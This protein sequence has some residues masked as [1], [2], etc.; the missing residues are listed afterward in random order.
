MASWKTP[1]KNLV[2]RRH[3]SQKAQPA[4][5]KMHRLRSQFCMAQEVG[6]VLGGRKI[7]QRSLP[8][9][10]FQET[11]RHSQFR[12]KRAKPVRSQKV[13][14]PSSLGLIGQAKLRRSLVPTS[15]ETLFRLMPSPF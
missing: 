3:G 12:L 8:I 2:N 13:A 5:E 1:T 10:A 11:V 6:E 4:K 15:S 14:N 7:L 9:A